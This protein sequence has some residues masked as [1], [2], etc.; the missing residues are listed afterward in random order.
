MSGIPDRKPLPP[1]PGPLF[2]KLYVLGR[3]T[4]REITWEYDISYRQLRNLLLDQGVTF[5][6]AVPRDIVE[7]A[8]PEMVDDYAKMS[9]NG[10]K[11]KYHMDRSTIVR[12]LRLAGVEIRSKGRPR[13]GE[14]LSPPTGPHGSAQAD[15]SE[16]A[17]V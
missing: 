14:E 6:R 9:L 17:L 5:R 10:M 7:P 3:W 15:F 4:L 8:T 13:R 1:D 16:Q 12:R 2:E 11:A